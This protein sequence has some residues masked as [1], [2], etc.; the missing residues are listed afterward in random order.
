MSAARRVDQAE[1][2]IAEAEK[3]L[4]A[5]S[6]FFKSLFSSPTTTEDAAELFV[7]AG[8]QLKLAKSWLR[9][10]DAFT[11]AAETYAAGGS[12]TE[13]EAAS[14]YAE[15]GKMYKNVEVAKAIVAF[16][17][18]VKLH[19]D[20]ARFQSCARFT[21]E[22]A[23]LH[24]ANGDATKAREAYTAAADFFDGEDAKSNANGMR[25]KVAG[26]AAMQGDYVVAAALFEDIAKAAVESRLLKYGAREHLLR[27]GLCRCM[28]DE[29]AAQ[30]AV[31]RYVEIDGSFTGSREEEL[32][33]KIVAAVG[34]GDVEAFTNAVYTYDSISKLDDWKTSVL[35][36]IKNAI[37][38]AEDDLT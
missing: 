2:L 6:S 8:N 31:E 13:F 7:R 3:K 26:I 18:A 28:E 36:K 38:D 29:I 30:R 10:G 16:E 24:E 20:G 11:R 1:N 19:S 35:L 14:K 5:K 25:V 9:A 12:D 33:R 34:E 27:A 37:R 17:A 4:S 32:L 15:A 23:E 22:I 21:R